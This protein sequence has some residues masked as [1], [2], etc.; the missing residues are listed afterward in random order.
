[1]RRHRFRRR[2]TGFVT[3]LHIQAFAGIAHHEREAALAAHEQLRLHRHV[4]EVL[5]GHQRRILV[6]LAAVVRMAVRAALP[7]E[8]HT[9]GDLLRIDLL[10]R[11]RRLAPGIELRHC[12]NIGLGPGLRHMVRDVSL[13]LA[14]GNGTDLLFQ[15]SRQLAVQMGRTRH[16]GDTAHTVTLR[17]RLRQLFGSRGERGIGNEQACN[18]NSSAS[19]HDENSWR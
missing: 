14:R 7:V 8:L 2:P 6:R 18:K 11:A 10:L 16:G 9:L 19:R 12:G 15:V 17:A 13:A 5:R 3:L 4:S 1:M